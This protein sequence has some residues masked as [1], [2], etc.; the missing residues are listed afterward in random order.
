MAKFD[1]ASYRLY[2][3]NSI[4]SGDNKHILVEG[5]DDKYLIERLWNDLIS[6][7]NNPIECRLLVDSA[8]CL[9]K[10]ASGPEV[11]AN[12]REKVEHITESV[13]GKDYALNFVGFVDRELRKFEWDIDANSQFKDLIEAHDV[14]NRLVLSRGHSIENYVFDSCILFQAL[15]YLSTT[16]YT[17]QAIDLFRDLFQDTLCIACSIGLA[18]TKAHVLSKSYS[19]IDCNLFEVSTQGKLEFKLDIW[20]EKLLCRGVTDSQKQEVV[21]YY[22]LYMDQILHSSVSLVRWICH[23]HIGYDCLRAVYERCILEKCSDETSPAKE[24]SGISWV[25]KDRLLYSF[26]NSWIKGCLQN[27]DEY[28]V[29]IF[30]LLQIAPVS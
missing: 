23:G 2:L 4:I 22:E 17:R 24:T 7:S 3:Q 15:E 20:I 29:A 16:A 1:P 13:Q 10:G 30:Q 18:A 9:I 27:P 25:A 19:T 11:F 8:E 21:K 5:K 12:N 28:P 14:V 6:Q 26:I